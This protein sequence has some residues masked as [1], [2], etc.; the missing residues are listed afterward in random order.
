MKT[1]ARLQGAEIPEDDEP[2][3][4]NRGPST[5]AQRLME[6]KNEK[7]E[8]GKKKNIGAYSGFSHIEV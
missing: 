6:N 1:M 4:E 7:A 3:E 2:Q 8:E 5:L